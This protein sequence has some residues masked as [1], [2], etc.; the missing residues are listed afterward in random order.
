MIQSKRAYDDANNVSKMGGKPRVRPKMCVLIITTPI[1]L[2]LIE[3]TVV[4]VEITEL[5]A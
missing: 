5:A 2:E 1:T 3:Y 4:L